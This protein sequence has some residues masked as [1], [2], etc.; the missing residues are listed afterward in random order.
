MADAMAGVA[1]AIVRT[2]FAPGWG[3]AHPACKR[4]G[5]GPEIPVRR[6]VVAKSSDGWQR[7]DT[8]KIRPNK[9]SLSPAAKVTL[10]YRTYSSNT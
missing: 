9:A 5:G 1:R 7:A 10:S 8:V 3:V 2:S 6:L 4:Q